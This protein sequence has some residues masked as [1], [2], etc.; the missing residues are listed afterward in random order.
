MAGGLILRVFVPDGPFRRAGKALQIEAFVKVFK[1]KNFRKAAFGYFGHM[2][3]L[4]ALWTFIPVFILTFDPGVQSMSK[5]TWSFA[6]IA[7]GGIGCVL[8]G[9]LA[10]RKGNAFVAAFS[11]ATSG[12]IC[13]I[14]PLFGVFPM[15]ISYALLLAWGF[16]VVSDSPQFSSLVAKYASPELKGTALTIVNCIG[17]AITILSIQLVNLM[18]QNFDPRYMFLLL[19][20]GPVLG[21]ISILPLARQKSGPNN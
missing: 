6:I 18:T 16:F 4:Y 15:W 14:S 21:L 8:G 1:H 3:E 19:V 9:Y 20:P 5:S 2:W 10:Q 7:F 17:F 13:L 11:I 12:F